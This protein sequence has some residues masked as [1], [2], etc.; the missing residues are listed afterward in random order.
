MKKDWLIKTLVIGIIFFFISS[1]AIQN[2][3]GNTTYLTKNCERSIY[4]NEKN[5]VDQFTQIKADNSIDYSPWPMF[6]HDAKHTSRSPYS[7]AGNSLELKWIFKTTT[8][9]GTSPIV[10]NNGTIYFTD[11]NFLYA[12]NPN[13]TEK[14]RL[15][16]ADI[17][18]TPA[19]DADGAIYFGTYYDNYFYAVYPNG[20]TKWVFEPNYGVQ[21]PP[22]IGKDGTIYFSTFDE[23]GRFYALNPDGTEKWQY[24]ADF[25]CHQSAVIDDDGI[26]YFASHFSL[27][28]FYPNG[29]LLWRLIIGSGFHWL[30]TPS[31]GLDGT[32]YIAFDFPQYL[33]AINPNGTIKW[34]YVFNETCGQAGAAP[35]IGEDGTIY[36]AYKH[37]YAIYPNGTKKWEF[38]PDTRFDSYIESKANTI[39]A[40]GT[41]YIVTTDYEDVYLIALNQNGEE[42]QRSWV[43]DYIVYSGPVIAPDGTI[44]VGSW[45]NDDRG[46]LS[47]FGKLDSNAPQAPT[48]SGP[49]RGK[50][51]E[52]HDYYFT[53]TSP[54]GKDIYYYIDWDDRS[55]E[56]WIGPYHSGETI[57]VSHIWKNRGNYVIGV[58][59]KDTDNLCSSYVEFKVKVTLPRNREIYNSLYLIFLE[60]LPDAFLIFRYV[61]R[62]R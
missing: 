58:R 41:I 22:T 56:R 17:G 18:S 21:T 1:S 49:K 3:I 59:V 29:T 4:A 16:I 42:I 50:I 60:Q 38:T 55:V 25:F 32:I 35:S 53:S 33:Y 51:G 43:S 23:Y 48:I 34:K 47:A 14:W 24:D 9:I 20:T 7:T 6:G 13:G 19:I 52:P 15:R 31:I 46:S 40:D 28:A 27:Y 44:Y 62:G 10:D 36:F 12:L 45:D 26:V 54:L 2:S 8:M 57:N 30:S 37:F 61:I 11:W 5:S 39:S